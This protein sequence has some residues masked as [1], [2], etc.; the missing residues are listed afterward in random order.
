MSH[1]TDIRSIARERAAQ[2]RALTNGDV[3]AEALLAAAERETGVSRVPLAAGDVLLD[4]GDAVYDPEP[5]LIWYNRDVEAELTAMYQAHEYAHLWLGHSGR[6]HCDTRDLDPESPDEPVPLGV[7]R[8]EGYGPKER[9]ERDANVF[10]RELLLPTDLLRLWFIEEGLGAVEI[11]ER[12]GVPPGVV[13]HQLAYAVLVG[14]LPRAEPRPA[15]QSVAGEANRPAVENARVSAAEFLASLDPSQQEAACVEQGPVLVEAGPGTGKTRT[16]VG[17]VLHLLDR[18]V[19]PRSILALTY[20]N[21]AAEEMRERVARVAPEAAPLIW[22]GTFHAFGLDLLRKYGSRIGLPTDPPVL[23]P[24]DAMFLLEQDLPALSL[25]HYQ[26]LPE[27]TRYLKPILA[28]ISRAKDEL[29]SPEDDK[30]A[31]AEM[32]DAAT[33]D[34][35]V[36]EAERAVEVAHVYGV[37]QSVLEERGALDFGDL[38]A[39]S[40]ALLGDESHG[41]GASVRE[42]YP[43]VLV[44]EYQDVN[45]ASAILLAAVA[46]D[47]RGLWVV[48]DARQSIY[49]FRGAA[50]SN[51]AR[52]TEDFP[53][54]R[55][56]R[57]STN[58][59]SQPSV[60][61]AVSRFA[62]GMP[63]ILG[64]EFTPWIAHRPHDGGAVEM[65]IA[66]NAGAEG[67]GIA[68]EVRRHHERGVQYSEQAVLCR[69]HTNLA[70]VGSALEAAG[71][72]VLYLGDLFE[73]AEVRDMLAL[74]SL[75]CH[76]D[77]RGL[78]RVA[79]FPEYAIP[80]ADVRA[81]LGFAR[82]QDLPFPEA[83]ARVAALPP[84]ATP[85]SATGHGGVSRLAEH[86]HQLCYGSEAWTMLSRYLF[87]R[88]Y[89]A[90]RLA[91]DTTLAG[92]QRRL[93]LYQFLQFAYEQR[94]RGRGVSA[95]LSK[96]GK[97]DPKRG[98][99]RFV[100]RL[101]MVGDDTQLRQV[102]EWA[103]TIDAVRLM[104]VHASKGLEFPVV[105]V[106]ALGAGMFPLTPKWN[107]CPL[108]PA[109]LDEGRDARA[110]H[111]WEEECLFFVA[112]SRSQ[113]FLYLSRALTYDKRGSKKSPSVFL[114][115]LDP[116]LPR[117]SGGTTPTWEDAGQEEIPDE[118]AFEVPALAIFTARALDTYLSCPRRYLYEIVLEL[119]ATRDDSAYLEM[120]GCVH[121]VIRWVA[122]RAGQGETVDAIE[123]ARQLAVAWNQRGPR[124]HPYEPLYRAAAEVLVATA[125]EEASRRQGRG[126][127]SRPQWTVTLPN[128]TVTV[129]P[130]EVD[131]TDG[132]GRPAV[133][134]RRVRTGRPS[135]SETEK[136]LYAL[137]H[138][139]AT[140]THGDGARIEIS[141]LATGTTEPVS[142]TD[143]T[144]KS[145]VG[146][147]NEAMAAINRGEFPAKPDEYECPRCAQYFICP[148]AE[149]GGS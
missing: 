129:V 29:K 116:V 16:L 59:R 53:G 88:S 35:D 134:V 126:T 79:R 137:L 23:D 40:V 118:A 25:D 145:R 27:P 38:I 10:A 49:R 43:H 128:G 146:K 148:M 51:M 124:D 125:L 131:L 6:S 107:A 115:R 97:E 50:P 36:H 138:A 112:I 82:E 69:S 117:P 120:H 89:Y 12:V 119:R 103:A 60:V 65:E 55:V 46:G 94:R 140:H 63:A 11:A 143:K 86:L 122:E 21:K 20:S 30:R 44:D 100:R 31:A 133:V 39:R 91:G 22:M 68:A 7:H 62:E 45:R 4:G 93:A 78:V 76:G 33:D 74:L 95:G 66:A 90:R 58:Y 132:Q 19:D 41:V 108:P 147:Y 73:R 15:A 48:G 109:L 121:Q 149:D 13:Y 123:A 70:R 85:L 37:Y 114:A 98:F 17:R 26:H 52:F 111:E 32:R 14:D 83:L 99:L 102:P 67:R 130:D 110:E 71:I 64:V 139:A 80:L 92:R 87:E 56:L 96:S 84:D 136:P 34:D 77:G 127:Q 57:L 2:L 72:P 1:V 113:D 144:L 61:A 104:T 8:V 101:A 28:A 106:P 3:R 135:K 9:R 142:L 75:A 5:R 54:G 24:V 18:D 81:T 42:A 47:G 141:Y 105:Y